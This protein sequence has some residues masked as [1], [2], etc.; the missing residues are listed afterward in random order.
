MSDDTIVRLHKAYIKYFISNNFNVS[1]GQVDSSFGFEKVCDSIFLYKSMGTESLCPDIGIGFKIDHWNNNYTLNFSVNQLKQGEYLCTFPLD[2]KIVN[3]GRHDSHFFS[4]RFSYRPKIFNFHYNEI[5][6]LGFSFY[7]EN[8]NYGYLRY[9]V[10]PEA[11]S[12]NTI[13][14]L[15]TNSS[16][17]NR[18][19]KSKKKYCFGLDSGIQFFSF[20]SN[21]ELNVLSI[22]NDLEEILTYFSYHIE[23]S[24]IITGQNRLFIKKYGSWG[25]IENIFSNV[26]EVA[27]RYSFIN[28]EVGNFISTG[29]AYNK[30][31]CFNWYFNNIK[32]GINYIYSVQDPS[33]NA[34]FDSVRRKLYILGTGIQ[35][36]Y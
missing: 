28:F 33:I 23:L 2:S 25:K 1:I 21:F 20:F 32:I 17:G 15:D 5:F 30:T 6:Q 35:F 16:F 12:R 34:G 13:P 27:F 11:E 24:Y 26:F 9:K 29:Q 19:L 7:Y 10:I 4:L 18:L 3:S 14:I 8:T 31:F 36:Q 22:K